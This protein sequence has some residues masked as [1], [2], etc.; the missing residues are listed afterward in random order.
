MLM[1]HSLG[2][3]VALLAAEPTLLPKGVAVRACVLVNAAL[4]SES[5]DPAAP[6]RPAD[7]PEG[8]GQP[9][10]KL[11]TPPASAWRETNPY[12]IPDFQS[13]RWASHFPSSDLRSGC[14]WIGRFATGSPVINLYSRSEDVLSP[15]PADDSRWPGVLAVSAHGAWIYQEATKGRWPGRWVNPVQSQAGWS[16]SPQAS[17]RS[18]EL[19]RARGDRRLEL[20]RTRPLFSDFREQGLLDGRI[21]PSSRGSRAVARPNTVLR[22]LGS[23]ALPSGSVWTVR[24][25]LLAHAIPALAPAAGAMPIAGARNYRMDGEGPEDPA[26]PG[27]VPFPLGWPRG[28]EVVDHR[29]SPV[30]VWRHSDWRNVAYPYVHPAFAYVVREAGLSLPSQS[31]P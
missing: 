23:S 10:H 15:P 28:V 13:A 26:A 18:A 2:G 7:Y 6:A 25:E 11:M 16:P 4:P 3:Y 21:G 17:R 14:R 1:G 20:L 30:P 9:L 24:D 31:H 8:A 29:D 5:L 27:L 19:L 22:G 12:S